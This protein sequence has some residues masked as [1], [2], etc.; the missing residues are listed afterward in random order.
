MTTTQNWRFPLILALS[1]IFDA[2][3]LGEMAMAPGDLLEAGLRYVAALGLSW[4]GVSSII[5][6]MESYAR[7][8][9]EAV[10]QRQAEAEGAAT[11]ALTD[12]TG[13]ERTPEPAMS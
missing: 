9:A 13:T 4:L 1:V 3:V 11:V 6:L 10:A 7:Q 12:L 2:P 5:R 8:N